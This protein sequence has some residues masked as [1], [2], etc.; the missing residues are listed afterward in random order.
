MTVLIIHVYIHIYS[1]IY[2]RICRYLYPTLMLLNLGKEGWS[3]FG[4]NGFSGVSANDIL[5]GT[6]I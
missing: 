5:Q 1:L 2:E 3:L 4:S 6:C